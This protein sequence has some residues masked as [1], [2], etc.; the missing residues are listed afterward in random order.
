VAPHSP[1]EPPGTG[2]EPRAGRAPVG[3][4]SI[5]EGTCGISPLGF[6]AG[7]SE[8]KGR[9][10]GC[11]PVSPLRSRS[12][13]RFKEGRR[14]ARAPSAAKLVKPCARTPQESHPA[15]GQETRAQGSAS[16]QQAL[17]RKPGPLGAW[18]GVGARFSL[19]PSAATRPM[20]S[21]RGGGNDTLGAA[22]WVR[23]VR[24][25]RYSRTV[26]GGQQAQRKDRKTVPPPSLSS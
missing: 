22:G 21:G 23:A 26:P 14:K 4:R 7:G 5:G 15:P 12:L 16:D 20:P 17:L 1:G 9:G 6:R 11:S 8:G 18:D 25:V 13:G 3:L 19:P 10:A 24:G 2:K